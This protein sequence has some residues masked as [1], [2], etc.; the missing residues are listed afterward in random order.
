MVLV[1]S[2]K[3]VE[4]TTDVSLYNLNEI[5]SSLVSV[6]ET[7]MKIFDRETFAPSASVLGV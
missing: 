5:V 1:A 2:V 3:F 4:L 7:F 6:T